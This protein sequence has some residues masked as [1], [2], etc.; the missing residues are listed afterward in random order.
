MLARATQNPC[1]NDPTWLYFKS[2]WLESTDGSLQSTQNSHAVPSSYLQGPFRNS[3]NG[4][5]SAPR[6]RINR[7]MNSCVLSA[8]P[9]GSWWHRQ[10]QQCRPRSCRRTAPGKQHLP[11]L[12]RWKSHRGSQSTPCQSQAFP[13]PP[14]SPS[15][16]STPSSITDPEP[17]RRGFVRP[18]LWGWGGKAREAG[19]QGQSLIETGEKHGLCWNRKQDSRRFWAVV[20]ASSFNSR[21][22]HYLDSFSNPTHIHLRVLCSSILALNSQCTK[23][24][25]EALILMSP[26]YKGWDYKCACLSILRSTENGKQGFQQ[27]PYEPEPV[28]GPWHSFSHIM[29]VHQRTTNVWRPVTKGTKIM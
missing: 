12:W 19:S 29:C 7:L 27:A 10:Q 11:W 3:I 8:Q 22:Q 20:P 16:L 25:F 26:L 13:R 28:L 23:D 21:K 17:I 6:K 24:S 5:P 18:S 1:S 14:Q 2:V 15:N 4:W 9:A